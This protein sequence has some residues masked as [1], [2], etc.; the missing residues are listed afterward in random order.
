ML[1]FIKSLFWFRGRIG[2]LRY[3]SSIICSILLWITSNFIAL[4]YFKLLTY[5]FLSRKE[6]LIPLELLPLF[7]C[8]LQWF[9]IM[10][11]GIWQFLA[12]HSKR[13]HDVGW[14]GLW[15]LVLNVA[16]FI[17]FWKW[18]FPLLALNI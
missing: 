13:C 8:F 15:P 12:S 1:N 6:P 7:G 3:L 11:F 4:I 5:D 16:V 9:A 2:R 10:L 14:G 18:P 17:A